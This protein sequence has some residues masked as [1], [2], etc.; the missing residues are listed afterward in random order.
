MPHHRIH[1]G[2]QARQDFERD[3]VHFRSAGAP[4]LGLYEVKSEMENIWLRYK[5][6]DAYNDISAKINRDMSDKE[7]G[8]DEFIKPIREALDNA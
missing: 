5:E 8:I 3:H 4:K 1:A 7:K 6:P 2:I